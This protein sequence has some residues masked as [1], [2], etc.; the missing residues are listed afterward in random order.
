ML[1]NLLKRERESE[2]M[3]VRNAKT[4]NVENPQSRRI[5]QQ[6][7]PDGGAD[8]GAKLDRTTEPFSSF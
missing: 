1:G 4:M 6:V 7:L 3:S 8:G 5:V 2:Q